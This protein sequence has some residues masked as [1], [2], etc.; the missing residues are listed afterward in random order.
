MINS[1]TSK[2]DHILALGKSRKDQRELG[3]TGEASRS[4]NVFVK[5]FSPPAIA[6]T[7]LPAAKTTI[8]ATHRNAVTQS[9]RRGKFQTFV[10]TCHFVMLEITLDLG[11]LL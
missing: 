1:G 5:G 2:L 9:D 7:E 6:A 11:G 4:K 10:P 8:F 3:F